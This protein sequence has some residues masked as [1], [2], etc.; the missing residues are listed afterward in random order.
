MTIHY[1]LNGVDPTESDPVVASGS[2]VTIDYSAT[3]KVKAF[4]PAW[5]PSAV[6]S[7]SYVIR[8]PVVVYVD[9]NVLSTVQDG[10]SWSTAKKT[11]SAGLSA[12]VSGD[13]V[14][15]AQ[16]TYVE[17]VTLVT[18]VALYGGFPSGG[19]DWSSR[20]PK[21]NETIVDGNQEGSCHNRRRRERARRL[22]LMDSLSEM[23]FQTVSAT[24]EGCPARPPRRLFRTT[25]SRLTTPLGFSVTSPP[26]RDFKQHYHGKRRGR[27]I[28]YLSGNIQ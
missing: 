7:A 5:T 20:S 22:L 23:E 28:L 11:I 8:A 2:S 14:W 26:H 1:T 24:A 10:T 21:T 18:G 19:G 16:G 17:Q 9:H 15:V 3:L 13:Q 6:S 25:R 4:V 27:N 12:A